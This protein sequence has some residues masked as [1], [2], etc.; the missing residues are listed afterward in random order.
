MAQ[1]A[2]PAF[3]P[4]AG[5]AAAGAPAKTAGALWLDELRSRDSARRAILVREILGPPIALR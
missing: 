4:P 1:Q 5:A 3:A 2:I